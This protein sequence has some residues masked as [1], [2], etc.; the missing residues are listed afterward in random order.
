MPRLTMEPAPACD[1]GGACGQGSDS[2][3]IGNYYAAQYR[4][5][6][7][8]AVR[9]AGNL[10]SLES[11]TL[12]FLN[13]FCDS[14]VP[15]VVKEAAL[16]TLTGLRSQT[17]FRT[18]DG[19]VY[20]W[21]GCGDRSGCC[22]GSCTHVWNY[23]HATGFLFGDLAQTMREVE[24]LHATAGN[25]LMN[26]RVHLPLGRSQEFGK[27]AADGQMGAIMRLYREW[28]L[29]GDEAMLRKAWPH[30]RKAIEFCWVPGGWDADQDGVM[31]GCQ[32][33]TMDVEYY[34]PNGQMGIWYL[35]ALRACQEMAAFVGEAHFADRCRK[36]FENGSAW[37]DANLF[38]GEFYEQ[39]VM[40]PRSDTEVAAGLRIGMGGG[41]MVDPDW[42]LGAACLVDQLVGQYTAHVLG[43]GYLVKPENV[44]KT[45]ASIKKYNF[46]KSLFN[47]FNHLR[48]FVLNGESATLM[49]T[50]PLGRRPKAPF[51]Y[52]NEVMTGFEY[53]AAIGMLQEGMT[54]D[55]MELIAAVRSRYTGN[56]RSPFD[57][58][59]CGHHYAR[60]MA[61]WAAYVTLT[62]FAYSGVSKT[63]T[64]AAA[65]GKT[66]FWSNG[67][68]WG[69]C[70]QA[71]AKGGAEVELT[72]LHGS[73]TLKELSLRGLGS[74]TFKTPRTVA[75][76]KTVKLLVAK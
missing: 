43:L 30:A 10:P 36:L 67:Y 1:C 8:A 15:R 75:A 47:H 68:A 37:I 27:G 71:R 5:A 18:P 11:R 52:C 42:Q 61:T 31:E 35:G 13:A 60:A 49:A 51:P 72:V 59:E 55:G 50:Y 4:D 58:A 48:S 73:L 39:K 34:G 9:T 2:D 7:D 20:G 46:K 62:G 40:P 38:N 16:Y 6:W 44:R 25:G 28:Q 29:S 63:M 41:N 22:F 57:E 26:F 56:N 74:S 24:F 65:P 17:T 45:L 64:F 53:T 33:N 76:G 70:R 69:T 66:F 23:E 32:H 54:K 21:E 3:V 19:R 12:A 14:D